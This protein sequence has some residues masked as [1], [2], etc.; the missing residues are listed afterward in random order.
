[1]KLQKILTGIGIVLFLALM[2]SC[3][4]EKKVE[5]ETTAETA[6]EVEEWITLF[7]GESLDG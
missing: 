3:T 1:M 6:A 2:I 7:D 4:G 5:E